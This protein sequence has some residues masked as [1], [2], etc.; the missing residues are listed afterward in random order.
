MAASLEKYVSLYGGIILAVLALVAPFQTLVGLPLPYLLVLTAFAALLV[1]LA[2]VDVLVTKDGTAAAAA[3]AARRRRRPA[4]PVPPLKRPHPKLR[5]AVVTIL[6]AALAGAQV[7]F[8]ALRLEVCGEATPAS[9][10]LH[11]PIRSI[12]EVDFA[13]PTLKP[14]HCDVGPLTSVDKTVEWDQTDRRVELHNF[15]WPRSVKIVCGPPSGYLDRIRNTPA[16]VVSLDGGGLFTFGSLIAAAGVVLWGIA[17]LR[18]RSR[19]SAP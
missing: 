4:A 6:F 1:L 11:A 5:L 12:A 9:T 19:R 16:D 2:T 13:L 7:Y 17:Y 10:V 18:W 8:L 3:A 14:D 15:V